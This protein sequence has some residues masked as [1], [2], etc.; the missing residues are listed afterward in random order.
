MPGLE[1]ARADA[2]HLLLVTCCWCPVAGHLLP[3][4][5]GPPRT[6]CKRQLSGIPKENDAERSRRVGYIRGFVY[7]VYDYYPSSNLPDHM[8]RR[9]V[10]LVRRSMRLH[11]SNRDVF[12]PLKDFTQ[13]F[14]NFARPRRRRFGSGHP[15]TFFNAPGMKFD[16]A[17]LVMC[18]LFL[19]MFGYVLVICYVG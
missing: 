18:W 9:L 6:H 16:A 19:V 7:T 4:G 17:L 5:R 1:S 3:I 13:Q 15:Q 8:M 11:P 14:H 12:R 10:C 2:G